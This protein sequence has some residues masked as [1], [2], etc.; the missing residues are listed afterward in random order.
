MS[1]GRVDL[2]FNGR[3]ESSI[4]KDSVI[5]TTRA[6]LGSLDPGHVLHVLDGFSIPLI[7]EG[8][9]MVH[10]RVPLLVDV[11]VAA[12]AGL[13]GHEKVG[14][15]GLS[16]CGGGRRRKERAVRSVTFFVHRGR[17]VSG[18]ANPI[19][20]RGNIMAIDSDSQGKKQ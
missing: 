13:R 7:V 11:R 3:I 1:L 15:N 5:V 20:F 19:P 8:R 2:L 16:G 18:I 6:P 10:G 14:R 17:S 4:E 9:K 12:L